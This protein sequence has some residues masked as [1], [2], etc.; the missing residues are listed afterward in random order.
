MRMRAAM[1]W[2]RDGR[3]GSR[4]RTLTIASILISIVSLGAAHADDGQVA[5]A[6]LELTPAPYTL[7]LPDKVGVLGAAASLELSFEVSGRVDRILGQG[8]RVEEGAVV[9]ELDRDLEKAELRRSSLLLEEALSELARVHGLQQSRAA[10]ESALETATTAVGLRRAERDAAQER[11][12]RRRLEARFAG[13][14]ADVQIEPGEVT[15]PGRPVAKLLNFDLMKLEVGVP[16]RQVGQV[17]PGAAVELR[18]PALPGRSFAGSVH[19]VAPSAANGGALFEVEILVPN[20]EGQLK[21]GMSARASIMTRVVP[22]ALVL[23]LQASVLRDGAR[24]VFFVDAGQARAVDVSDAILHGDRLVLPGETRPR[25]LVVRGQ[26]DLR[27]GSS[28]RVDASVL[29][30][31]DGATASAPRVEVIGP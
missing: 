26:H 31:R 13:V 6:T 17:S 21:P 27:D 5:V 4:V 25:A 8:A 18:V 15:V 16:G 10:S 19:H 1:R 20:A 11:L 23:P 30:G 12:D 7:T 3:L 9:A 14:V 29:E 22:D 28:V 24:V 2:T